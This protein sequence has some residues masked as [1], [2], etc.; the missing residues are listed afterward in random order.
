[1]AGANWDRRGASWRAS[2]SWWARSRRWLRCRL[3]LGPMCGP[4][5]RPVVAV[6]V[7]ALVWALNARGV[8][9]TA[10]ATTVD[11][12]HR[13]RGARRRRR[14][15]AVD[16]RRARR[17]PRETAPVTAMGVASAAAL[18]FF[19][20]AGYARLAT[21][22]EEVRD[23]ARTIPRAVAIAVA[24]VVVVYAT[25]GAVLLR[26]PGVAALVGAERAADARG[27][28]YRVVALGPGRSGRGCRGRRPDRAHGG[29]RPYRHGDGARGGPSSHPRPHEPHTGVPQRAEAVAGVAAIALAWWADL[30]FR[31]RDVERLGAHVL[32]DSQRVRVRG[33]RSRDRLRD[34]ARSVGLGA[35]PMPCARAVPRS[36][37]D[38]C[39]GRCGRRRRC[40]AGGRPRGAQA[41]SGISNSATGLS[42]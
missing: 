36:H 12:R 41:W 2:G 4:L 24:I 31:P 34:P 10:W 9:R 7:V 19:A 30:G 32:R 20:F 14:R 22:G 25:L 37:A 11:C 42:Q 23:P 27:P 18:I 15:V 29:D 40:R 6:V 28:G 3:P 16:T 13:A 8:K 38:A 17:A 26:R 5:T 21:L 1:M 33:T 39:R 35:R